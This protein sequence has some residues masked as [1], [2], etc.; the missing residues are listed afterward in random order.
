MRPVMRIFEDRVE[1]G[2]RSVHLPRQDRAIYVREGA[3]EF[4][5]DTTTQYL[6]QGHGVTDGRQ[7]TITGVSEPT[8]LWRWELSTAEV[9]DSPRSAPEVASELKLEADLDLDDRYRWL[10]R[11]DTVT[12]P[13]GG[14][15][16]TH[17]HQGPGIRIVQHGQLAIEIDGERAVH[18]PGQAWLERGVDPVRAPNVHEG[19]TMFIRC[20]LLPE[21]CRGL[22][23]I[24]IVLPEDRAKPNSQS[25]RVLAEHLTGTA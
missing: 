10:M 18:S 19:E 1:A 9:T 17:V 2:A 21:Q 14:V 22:S 25:Y 5:T 24:R 11:L 3:A 4:V 20:F 16:L 13:P 6:S 8:V 23:S 15:A 7:L 12:F